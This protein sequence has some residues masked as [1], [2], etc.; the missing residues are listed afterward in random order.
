VSTLTVLTAGEKV[1][2]EWM[3]FETETAYYVAQLWND[4]DVT[5]R[6]FT[7]RWEADKDGVKCV[8]RKDD[9]S[10]WTE[11]V[12][13]YKEKGNYRTVGDVK[14]WIGSS[15]CHPKYNLL[16]HN[17]KHFCCEMWRNL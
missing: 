6:R 9:P 12:W 16:H 3:E 8:G 15:E 14:R 13:D 17:C 1:E 11:V 4:G 2:H 7:K 5:F 10:V